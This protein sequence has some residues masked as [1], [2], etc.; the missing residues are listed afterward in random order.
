M[1]FIEDDRGYL[2]IWEMPAVGEQYVIGADPSEGVGKDRSAAYVK[3]RSTGEYVARI[4]GQLY[5]E[6]FAEALDLL[7]RFYNRAYIC[8]EINNHGHV[9]KDRLVNIKQ[10]T[11]LY[12]RRET[13]EITG[14]W[15]SEIGFRTTRAEKDRIAHNF[16]ARLREG[17]LRPMDDDLITELTTFQRDENQRLGAVEGCHD[18]LAMAA[19][20][21]EEMDVALGPLE[22]QAPEEDEKCRI[23]E[24]TG[25]PIY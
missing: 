2:S 5:P 3:R 6:E 21:T 14:D 4:W 10:Y 15:K 20:F 7:G 13:E 23:D 18:D 9:V 19:L 12:H 17:K 11:N 1:E 8:F 22:L 24:I 16:V 25:Y